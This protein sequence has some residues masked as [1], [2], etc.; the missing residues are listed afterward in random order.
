MFSAPSSACSRKAIRSSTVKVGCFVMGLD[1]DAHDDVIEDRRGA[2]D[3][4][5]MTVG[6][7]VVAA[8]T[9]RG[10]GVRRAHEVSS[11]VDA[12]IDG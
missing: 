5:Q 2:V 9:D 3:D 10:D 6:H 8:G 7:R 1:D 11:V 12:V 4:V